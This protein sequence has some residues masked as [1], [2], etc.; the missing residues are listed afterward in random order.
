MK[1][2]EFSDKIAKSREKVSQLREQAH[3]ASAQKDDLVAEALEQLQLT[4]EEL[5]IAQEELRSL[6]EDLLGTRELVEAERLRYQNLFELAPDAYLVTSPEGIIREANQAAEQL[7]DI[8]VRFLIGK[9]IVNYIEDSHRKAFRSM[10][11][12]LPD[13]DSVQ[14]FEVRLKPRDKKPFDVVVRAVPMRD[15]KGQ[16]VGL[17]WLLHDITERKRT[18]DET[19][20][21]NVELERRVAKRTADLEAA[22]RIKEQLLKSEK[23][24]RAEAEA[25]NR[26]KDDFLATLSHELRTPLNAILGWTHI[27]STHLDERATVAQALEVIERNAVTQA[28]LIN[29]ILEVSRIITGKLSLS[30]RP[31]EIAPAVEAAIDAARPAVDAKAIHLEV[32][33]DPEAGQILGD[34]S[35]LQ[36]VVANLLSNAVRF[37]P[38]AGKITVTLTREG[39]NARL[40][41]SDTGQGITPDFLPFIFDRFRQADSATTR[42]YGGLGLGL[43][44]VRHIVEAHGGMVRATSEGEGHGASF[45]VELPLIDSEHLLTVDSEQEID[46]VY[47]PAVELYSSLEGLR[48]MVVDDEL[49]ACEMLSLLL[50]RVGAQVTTAGSCAEAI[51]MLTRAYKNGAGSR[52]HVLIADIAMPDGDGFDLIHA[53]REIEAGRKD[54]I[55]AIA[56]TAYAGEEDRERALAEGFQMHIAKPVRLN[57]LASAVIKLVAVTE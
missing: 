4:L 13:A 44:I 38:E 46:E 22:N 7:F 8:P 34:S 17:R 16:I 15:P 52:P 29:D 27:L 28:R 53:L 55:P 14:S 33:L 49:D 37:M 50:A 18:E 39:A 56:L 2:D 1:K 43:A 24:A 25:A 32:T 23:A 6:N 26:G 20:A 47:A 5:Q 35:R 41:V 30:L 10:M 48:I 42:R 31:I 36:Q 9:P 11:Y 19:K 3:S 40:T 12:S 21:M 57:E 54:Q 45:I 51:E